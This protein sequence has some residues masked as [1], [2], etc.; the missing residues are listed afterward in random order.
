[1]GRLYPHLLPKDAELWQRFID[2]PHN[3]FSKFDYDVR[4]G[5]R[6]DPGDDYPENLRTMWGDLTQR[7]IDAVGHKPNSITII[8]IS[9]EAGLT[10][11][12]QLEVYP[13]LYH[14]SFPNSQPISVLLI[15]E[16]LQN[17]I[18]EAIQAKTIPHFILPPTPNP[19]HTLPLSPGR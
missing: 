15:A 13:I 1:M 18:P 6:I 7:R 8:E 4:V 5:P 17:G 11:I 2:S 9:L 12:G 16:T 19:S 14:Q 3:D 10:Q